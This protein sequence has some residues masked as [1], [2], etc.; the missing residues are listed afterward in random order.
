MFKLIAI[1]PLEDCADYIRKCLKVDMLYYFCNDYVIAED[2]KSICRRSRNLKPL[3]DDF[4]ADQP[5]VNVSAIVGMNGDGKSTLVELLMRM[6]NNCSINYGLMAHADNLRRVEQVHAEL[7][8]LI[9]NVL[10]RMDER[11]WKLGSVADQSQDDWKLGEPEVVADAE[12][13]QH[14]FFTLVSNY[15]HYAYNIYDYHHEWEV[16]GNEEDDNEKCWLHYIFHKNDGYMTPITL[17]PYRDKGNIDVNKEKSLSKQRLLSLFLNA[18]NPKKNPLSFRRVNGKDAEVLVLKEVKESKLQQKVLLDYFRTA[19]SKVVLNTAI[20]QIERVRQ[21]DERNDIEYE[22]LMDTVLPYFWQEPMDEVMKQEGF[23]A[24][25]HDIINWLERTKA[26]VFAKSGDIAS[27]IKG[28]TELRDSGTTHINDSLN[29]YLAKY[30]KVAKLNAAQLGRL[31]TLYRILKFHK[32]APTIVTKDYES[33]S[34]EEKCQQYVA[35]KTWSILTT[36]PQYVK[37]LDETKQG[38]RIREYEKELEECMSQ[39]MADRESHVTRKLRQVFNFMDEGLQGDGLYE[40]LGHRTDDFDCLYVH[41]DDLDEHYGGKRIEA[42][43]L[44]PAIYEWDLEFKRPGE[45]YNS[46]EFD[47]FSS[48]EK[49]MLNS[50]G[51]IIYHIQNLEASSTMI[52]RSVNLILEEIEL[53]YHPEYQRGYINRL[54][55]LIRG[56]KLKK[57]KNVNIVFVTH[58]PFI[59]SDIPRCNVLFLEDG[60]AID[61]MQENTFGANIHSLLK[62]G[63][64]LPNLPMGEFAYQKIN[65]MFRK[66]NAG[67]VAAEEFDALYQ[68]ILRVGEPYLRNELL[69]LYHPL[70]GN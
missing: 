12:V 32:I 22:R 46:I 19:R 38:K 66:L 7:F 20:N 62:N 56:M 63:F 39:I 6:I 2:R 14:M 60:M 59:L 57:V 24:F 48:G 18:E 61:K 23:E 13:V 15:S 33:L 28:L 36:Y 27:V 26:K 29:P 9:D 43:Q 53:Y 30:W 21:D 64:F 44:P 65:E 4:F 5:Q 17:H 31:D 68:D 10:Y 8:Y 25:V 37:I 16:R 52:Y 11:I 35:Y 1:K 34:I 41:L 3:K 45:P 51:A 67:D 70:K 49:Q 54:L 69:N 40:R 47:S 42:D 50:L 55:E 58:S